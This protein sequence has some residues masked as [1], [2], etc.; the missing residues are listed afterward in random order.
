MKAK[1][2]IVLGLVEIMLMGAACGQK[3]EQ[4]N[5]QS[6][7]DFSLVTG[8]IELTVPENIDVQIN[9]EGLILTDEDLNY[10]MLCVVGKKDFDE[11]KKTPEVY[12]EGVK[13]AGLT[14]TKEV[15]LVTVSGREFAY[16]DYDNDSDQVLLAYSKAG[17][18]KTFAA[19][20]VRYGDAGDEDILKSIAK[21]LETGKETSAPDTTQDDLITK[22]AGVSATDY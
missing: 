15:E 14:I 5:R 21:I 16:F 19:Q 11:R 17:E 12:M 7:T 9:D 10:Q 4:K 1:I 2:F 8:G 3:D 18:G 6:Q 20:V 22:K 13:D